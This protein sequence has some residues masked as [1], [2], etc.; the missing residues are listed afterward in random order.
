MIQIDWQSGIPAYDQIVQGMIRL[1]AVGALASGQQLPSVRSFAVQ[2]GVNPNTVQKAY[3][4]LE[5]KGIIY[6]VAG[7][8]SFF[9]DTFDADQAIKNEVLAKLKKI[10]GEARRFG[11]SEQEALQTVNDTYQEGGNTND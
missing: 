7:K 1:K 2:L 11:I 6:S 5:N 4:I 8:G 9:A 10:A 3:L